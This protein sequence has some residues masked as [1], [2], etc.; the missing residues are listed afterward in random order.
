MEVARIRDTGIDEDCPTA[1]LDGFYVPTER[2]LDVLFSRGNDGRLNSSLRN[3]SL[4][5][6][7][8]AVGTLAS[9]AVFRALEVGAAT[10]SPGFGGLGNPDVAIA[11]ADLSV[12]G[13]TN[14]ADFRRAAGR[15]A[16]VDIPALRVRVLEEL[17][18]AAE[19]MGASL[20]AGADDLRRAAADH[21]VDRALEVVWAL[22]GPTAHRAARRPDLG[23]IAVSAERDLSTSR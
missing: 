2:Q 1:S 5:Q 17:G 7:G 22:H 16:R 15:G 19:R 4:V 11:I 12:S 9:A 13:A 23:W 20:V 6:W 8:D 14:L 10:A 21:V 18:T 3:D